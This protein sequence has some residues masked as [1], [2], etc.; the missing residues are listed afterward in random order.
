[1]PLAVTP[2]VL[3]HAAS[4]ELLSLVTRRAQA[5]GGTG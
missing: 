4:A 3:R 5:P 2:G 1:M